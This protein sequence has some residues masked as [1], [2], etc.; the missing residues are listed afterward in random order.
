[1]YIS[2][3]LPRFPKWVELY[4]S[5]KK[6]YDDFCDYINALYRILI[7]ETDQQQWIDKVQVTEFPKVF[8]QNYKFLHLGSL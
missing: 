4:A 7:V 2:N 8:P 6:E 5:V 3:A 1:V